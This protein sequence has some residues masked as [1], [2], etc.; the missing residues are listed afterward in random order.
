MVAARKPKRPTLSDVMGKACRLEL[1]LAESNRELDVQR[2]ARMIA[3]AQ[4]AALRD[5]L[6]AVL[7]T[8]PHEFAKPEAQAVRMAARALVEEM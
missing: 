3:E 4:R 1:A 5:A 7:A 2:D 8:I 6:R